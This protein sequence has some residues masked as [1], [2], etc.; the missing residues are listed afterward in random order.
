AA[1]ALRWAVVLGHEFTMEHL[2]EVSGLGPEALVAALE[3]LQRHALLRHDAPERRPG[4]VYVF[5]HDLVR[6]AVHADISAARRR[7]MHGRATELLAAE[8]GNGETA[9]R[10]I[11]HAE[12][13]GEIALAVRACVA[14]GRRCL[15]LF[16]HAEAAALARRGMALAAGLQD[17]EQAV[18]M[19][20]LM[21]V[22]FFADRPKAFDAVAAQLEELAG[23]ALDHGRLEHAR[24]GYQLMGFLR[25]EGG[26]W[27]DARRQML[28]AELVSRSTDERGRV[29]GMA[30]AARCL[31]LLER[32]LP[33]A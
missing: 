18:L 14:A 11:V 12:A 28:Q 8:G 21:E 33:E 20:E 2:G 9:A 17:P 15:R 29:L 23:R 6:R 31:A 3:S 27:T 4:A 25:W 7:L 19:L 24:L 5:A 1:E 13:A 26:N 30:E 22:S 10:M 32:D 16:A